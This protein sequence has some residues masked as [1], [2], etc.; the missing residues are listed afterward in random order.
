MS[1]LGARL[2]RLREA[3]KMSQSELAERSGVPLGSVRGYEQG[4]VD[5]S[6][7][8][9]TRLAR[10]LGVSL[11]ELVGYTPPKRKR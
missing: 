7:A 8:Q 10:A 3:A 11:D 9:A 5:P 1:D 6:L 4:R 2:K